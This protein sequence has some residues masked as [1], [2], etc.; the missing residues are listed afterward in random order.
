MRQHL[1]PLLLLAFVAGA[2]VSFAQVRIGIKAGANYAT[3]SQ[4]IQP[5]PK[6]PPTNPKGLGMQ[7]GGYL[8][9]PFSDLVGLRPEL[10]FSFRRMKTENTISNNHTNAQATINQQAGQFTGDET[11]LTETDQR[12]TY[13]Q[14]N[15][16][17]TLSPAEGLRIMVGPSFNF[18]MG[19]RQNTDV[20][21][22]L[23]GTFT[24]QGQQ[25]Q[26]VDIENFSTSKKKG[27][28]AIRDWRKADVMAMAGVGYTLAVGFDM[29][30]RFYRSLSTTYDESQ[31]SNRYRI[32]TNL[33]EFN[34]GWTFGG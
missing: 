8:E 18:L 17:L 5:D 6:D 22:N 32:W 33:I 11:Q 16:P 21:Y 19:G 29:D 34:V 9:V 15:A 7:F 12:L 23:K 26:N 2:T 10:G 27:S 31:G 30:L 20:T 1:R 4:K 25:A 28:A 24:A 3:G 13:F 14:V